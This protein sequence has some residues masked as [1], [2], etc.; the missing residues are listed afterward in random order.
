RVNPDSFTGTSDSLPLVSFGV[1]TDVLTYDNATGTYWAP[2]LQWALDP[3]SVAAI[4]LTYGAGTGGGQVNV[5]D[6]STLTGGAVGMAKASVDR[7]S[8]EIAA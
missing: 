1:R 3:T 4:R 7:E 2:G 5:I 6:P 8:G